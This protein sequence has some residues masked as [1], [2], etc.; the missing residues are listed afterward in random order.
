VAV[1]A[2]GFGPPA[3]CRCTAAPTSRL[4]HATAS[5]P[6]P[7]EPPLAPQPPAPSA[8][9]SGERCASQPTNGSAVQARPAISASRAGGVGAFTC[10]QVASQL[11]GLREAGD[12]RPT[13]TRGGPC[14]PPARAG[15]C[16]GCQWRGQ[17][18]ETACCPPTHLHR[19][20]NTAI[21]PTWAS[22]LHGVVVRRR[23]ERESSLV[24]VMPH[25]LR[26]RAG[27]VSVRH[28][29]KALTL[30]GWVLVGTHARRGIGGAG[31]NFRVA[32]TPPPWRSYLPPDIRMLTN[33]VGG[34]R[35]QHWTRFMRLWSLPGGQERAGCSRR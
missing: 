33:A 12:G 7:Q 19:T 18:L 26:M 27:G 28:A 31:S 25:T 14:E 16:E 23:G 32:A 13:R 11:R 15:G 34:W 1:A 29:V 17:P 4:R 24:S 35:A 30:L 20:F 10:P 21:R 3:C 5:P 2:T 6:A 22:H 8:G 9:T